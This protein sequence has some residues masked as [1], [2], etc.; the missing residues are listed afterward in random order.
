MD[1]T[2]TSMTEKLK[3]SGRAFRSWITGEAKSEIRAFQQLQWV[4]RH[5]KVPIPSTFYSLQPTTVNWILNEVMIN[6]RTQILELGAGA[7]TQTIAQALTLLSGDG[8]ERRLLSI[9]EHAGWASHVSGVVSRDGNQ[10]VGDVR[11][12]PRREGPGGFWYDEDKLNEV[13][14][15]M[16]PDLIIVDGPSVK[17]E[18]MATDRH[19]V[20]RFFKD[21]MNPEGYAVFV[22]DTSRTAE[23]RL[24][25]DWAAYM[26]VEPTY[27]NAYLGVAIQGPG[28]YSRPN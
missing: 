4:S 17:N 2:T 8:I 10:L 28:F 19:Q 20:F 24:I 23:K 5:I 22:D 26:N 11:H 6:G 12:V 9:E 3:A 16:Q 25:E 27:M 18:A 15:G 13:L 1:D 14:Q 7:S 21:R